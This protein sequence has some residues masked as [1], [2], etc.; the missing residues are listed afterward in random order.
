M[1]PCDLD[2]DLDLG[3]LDC[4]MVEPFSLPFPSSPLLSVEATG[5]DI[6]ICLLPF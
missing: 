3:G 2:L 4:D 6:S 1:L 5:S